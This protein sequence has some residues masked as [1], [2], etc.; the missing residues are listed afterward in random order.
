MPG[1]N[2][3]LVT[4]LSSLNDKKFEIVKISEGLP[5]SFGSSFYLEVF[6]KSLK[7]E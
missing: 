2:Q 6:L 3:G 7:F 1:L 4:V 5:W